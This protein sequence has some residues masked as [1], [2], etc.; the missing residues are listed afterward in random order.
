[1]MN[2]DLRSTTKQMLDVNQ[3]PEDFK[4]IL[5]NQWLKEQNL[6]EDFK[7]FINNEKD[8]MDKVVKDSPKSKESLEEVYN[9]VKERL[10]G[11]DVNSPSLSLDEVYKLNT[12]KNDIEKEYN[13]FDLSKITKD[14]KEPVLRD[15]KV[16]EFRENAKLN[17]KIE[18]LKENNETI[19][20]FAKELNNKDDKKVR[21][22]K[23][24]V[25]KLGFEIKLIDESKNIV[26]CQIKDHNIFY[27][28]NNPT[29]EF[30]FMA[31]KNV[32]FDKLSREDKERYSMEAKMTNNLL[33]QQLEGDISKEG[34]VSRINQ[35]FYDYAKNY[36]P[37]LIKGTTRDTFEFAKGDE[38]Y[39]KNVQIMIDTLEDP[40][41][42]EKLSNYIK[43]NNLNL[44]E[45]NKISS[46]E[47]K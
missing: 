5:H 45:E 18:F 4:I 27:T 30:K 33:K 34:V 16:N 31:D 37:K 38:R 42:R 47:M 46:L 12:I 29:N 11:I 24:T 43:E 41:E 39:D 36:N 44:V 17:Q 3:K 7:N 8:I 28:N 32:P 26:S 13:G 9:S 10:K 14:Y 25:D 1:M 21:E 40:F 22:I 19:L 35:Y 6:K 23:D 2:E 20:T 15:I